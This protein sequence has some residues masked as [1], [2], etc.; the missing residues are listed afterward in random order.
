MLPNSA[1]TQHPIPE[2]RPGR[3]AKS[4]DG[5]RFPFSIEPSLVMMRPIND[6]ERKGPCFRTPGRCVDDGAVRHRS[7][8]LPIEKEK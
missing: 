7:G 3:R 1:A 6:G 8:C 5:S 4:P 2:M